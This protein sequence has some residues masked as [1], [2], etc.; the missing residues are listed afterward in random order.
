MRDEGGNLP[1]T[2]QRA[3]ILGG[4]ALSR[5]LLDYWRSSMPPGISLINAYGPTEATITA[6]AHRFDRARD[7]GI[8]VGKPVAGKAVYILDGAQNLQATGIHGELYI[9][10]EGLSSGYLNREELNRSVF[11]EHPEFGRLYRTGDLGRFGADGDITLIGR[12]DYQTK[13]RGYR[14]ELE[15]VES[16][17]NALLQVD[18]VAVVARKNQ[19]DELGLVAFV[20]HA[21]HLSNGALQNLKRS[22]KEHLPPHYVPEKIVQLERLPLTTNDKIDRKKLAELP[23]AE[24]QQATEAPVTATEKTVAEIWRGLLK[25]DAID[26]HANFFD[27]GGHSLLAS[28]ML[29]SIKNI[30]P[31]IDPQ[32][33]SIFTATSLAEVAEYVDQ[34]LLKK[35]IT[36]SKHTRS[37]NEVESFEL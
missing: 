33:A 8:K 22:L 35:S 1:A 26:R 32:L 24:P 23:L 20:A 4:E 16:H 17:L 30:F 13:I 25:L 18:Q 15:E 19:L 3:L 2:G 21:E 9:G 5:D 31:G 6:A 12:T 27:L 14:I 34:L 37:S 7:D 11:L 29:S 28:R 36:Q 10:G